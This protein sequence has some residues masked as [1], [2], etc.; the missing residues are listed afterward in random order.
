MEKKYDNIKSE[1]FLGGGY[2]QALMLLEALLCND[3]VVKMEDLLRVVG[4]NFDIKCEQLHKDCIISI[5]RYDY[6][7]KDG[8]KYVCLDKDLKFC[9]L[10]K[11]K[12]EWKNV[13]FIFPYFDI[14][15]A[16]EICKT[17]LI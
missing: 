13:K 6:L 2:G 16:A 15:K 10:E 11:G 12:E 14:Y 7:A 4:R 5:D 1:L 17:N 3:K 9:I 8:K